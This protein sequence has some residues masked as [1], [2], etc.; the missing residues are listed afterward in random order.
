M[1]NGWSMMV[2]GKMEWMSDVKPLVTSVVKTGSASKDESVVVVMSM[3]ITMVLLL[4]IVH[5]VCYITGFKRYLFGSAFQKLILTGNEISEIHQMAFNG[6]KTLEDYRDI[7]HNQLSN[8]PSI[9]SVKNTI[10]HLDLS[11]NKLSHISDTYFRYE[12]DRDDFSRL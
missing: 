6:L 9:T 12:E 1:G 2:W 5:F 8:A 10:L 7:S 11:W 4:I 3:T